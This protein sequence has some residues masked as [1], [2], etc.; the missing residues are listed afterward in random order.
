MVTS[1][2]KGH[3]VIHA[4][5]GCSIYGNYSYQ[6]IDQCTSYQVRGEPYCIVGWELCDQLLAY[7]EELEGSILNQRTDWGKHI[8]RVL[9]GQREERKRFIVMSAWIIMKSHLV[10]GNFGFHVDRPEQ[11]CFSR[12]LWHVLRDCSGEHEVDLQRRFLFQRNTHCQVCGV[13]GGDRCA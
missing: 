7:Q 13:L 1:Q 9:G 5:L 8:Q 2:W 11:K 6:G 3:C 4:C 12:F 10:S